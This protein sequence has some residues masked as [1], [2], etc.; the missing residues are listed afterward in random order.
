MRVTRLRVDEGA[1]CH[2]PHLRSLISVTF[3]ECVESSLPVYVLQLQI[4]TR[5]GLGSI[6]GLGLRAR[7]FL[8]R[9]KGLMPCALQVLHRIRSL[10]IGMMH[11]AVVI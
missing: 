4:V 7:G 1:M 8:R 3:E 11:L 9:D 10:N 6:L 5:L 2:A